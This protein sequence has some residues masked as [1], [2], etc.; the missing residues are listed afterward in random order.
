LPLSLEEKSTARL[1]IF[2]ERDNVV[3]LSSVTNEEGSLLLRLSED[4]SCPVDT[5]DRISLL[6]SGSNSDKRLYQTTKGAIHDLTESARGLA[7]G[8]LPT[9]CVAV[10]F[11]ETEESHIFFGLTASGTLHIQTPSQQ[12]KIPSCTSFL[13][14][15]THLIYTTSSHLL[16]FIHLHSSATGDLSIPPDEPET[17]ERC[18]IIER[19]TKLVTVMPSAYSLVLQMP[20]GNLETIYPRALVLAGIRKALGNREYKQAFKIC[21]TQRVDMN[22]LHDYAPEQFLRDVELFVK[23]VKK[24]EWVDLVLSSLSEEDVSKTIYRDTI[25]LSEEENG[26][27]LPPQNVDILPPGTSKVNRICDAFLEVLHGEDHLQ[28]IVTAHVCKNPPDLSAGLALISDL[29]ESGKQAQLEQAISHIAFLAD[30]NQLYDTA[31]GLYDLD[32]ALLV[33]QQSQKDPREYLPYLQK[34][35]DMEL[36]RR[37]FSI[38][39]DLKRYP[40][41]LAHL[42]TMGEFE[43]LKTYVVKHDLYTPAI[44]AYRYDT[45][46][47]MD[48][49]R[50][51]ADFNS[52][53]NRYQE[54]GIAYEFIG[55]YPSSCEAYRAAGEWREC[56]ATASLASLSEE[57]I[58]EIAVGLADGLEEAK[59]FTAAATIHLEHLDDLE[60]AIRLLCR[61]YAFGD[62]IRLCA[63]RKKPELLIKL[64]DPG[65]V[66]ASANLTEIMA[67][68]KGQL[69]AQ[70]PRLRELRVKKAEDPMAFLDGAEG[71]ADIPDNISLAP[72]AMSTSAGTFMTRYT[73]QS[74]GTLATNATRKTSKNRRR[75]ERK[76]A[77]GKKGTVYE[78][79]YL[80][81]SIGRLVEKWNSMVGDGGRLV[82]GL[83]R[84]GMRERAIAVEGVMGEVHGACV[85]CLEE[86]FGG[87][88][89]RDGTQVME[90]QR[91]VGGEGVLI[92]AFQASQRKKVVPVVKGF[93]KVGLLG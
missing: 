33:A 40:K 62:A 72:S 4:G 8:K 3:V 90:G 14:T 82:V 92:E 63:V 91:I 59:D 74:D 5:D 41:A 71:G 15:A 20:R 28:S 78:E 58:E 50:L 45:P 86:V 70:I 55:D 23:Q 12:L 36:L 54:A 30:V 48:L 11:W 73:D 13:V 43:E 64:V 68:M 46:K 85:G 89:E 39:N 79:E 38:D 49:M 56:L 47:L 1:V 16:K 22:I 19:G 9:A 60:S 88:G 61:G 24:G 31:L 42:H 25:K 32:V 2:D 7:L 66:E 52:S 77:R 27:R 26:T 53:R 34:L 37:K 76:R 57:K 35:K 84:R 18:R 87:E 81:G 80:V 51:F 6:F 67:E 21:R 29:R 65:L 93:E 69:G 10:E 17:D 83:M 44:D 75:E